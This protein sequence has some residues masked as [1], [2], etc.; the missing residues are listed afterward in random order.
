MIDKNHWESLETILDIVAST[1]ADQNIELLLICQDIHPRSQ[2]WAKSAWWQWLPVL[3][4]HW[5]TPVYLVDNI[6]EKERER[7]RKGIRVFM[8]RASHARWYVTCLRSGENPTIL[9]IINT[10]WNRLGS[11]KTVDTLKHLLL[12]R[13]VEFRIPLEC[14]R[15]FQSRK[16][17]QINWRC[18]MDYSSSFVFSVVKT[19]LPRYS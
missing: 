6:Y 17:I 4:S 9:S 8:P 3:F 2:K 10:E 13:Y 11:T 7:E 1:R 15:W 14:Q 5:T 18:E 16:M 12:H 19:V